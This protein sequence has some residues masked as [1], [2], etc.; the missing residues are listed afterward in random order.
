MQDLDTRKESEKTVNS[1]L[2]ASRHDRGALIGHLSRRQWIRSGEREEPAS[3]QR[4]GKKWRESPTRVNK[5]IAL[6]SVNNFFNL[7]L[8]GLNEYLE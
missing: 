6:N 4:L 7:P 3:P 1:S 5:L 2:S 8:R